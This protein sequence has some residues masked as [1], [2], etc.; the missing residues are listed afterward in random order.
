MSKPR[1]TRRRLSSD[2][3]SSSHSQRTQHDSILCSPDDADCSVVFDGHTDISHYERL[4]GMWKRL[5]ENSPAAG[6]GSRDTNRKQSSETMVGG[7]GKTRMPDQP[8]KESLMESGA[9]REP[10]QEEVDIPLTPRKTNP[11]PEIPG[12]ETP[13][14]ASSASSTT[15]IVAPKSDGQRK[16]K[17][18][19]STG[20]I[21]PRR[22]S[23]KR[24]PVTK[25]VIT[26]TE[27]RRTPAKQQ[28]SFN[29]EHHDSPRHEWADVRLSPVKIN[30]RSNGTLTN[31]EALSMLDF[32][33]DSPARPSKT[34][35]LR[36]MAAESGKQKICPFGGKLF[37]EDVRFIHTGCSQLHFPWV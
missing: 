15:N 35:S 16:A 3:E 10:C 25:L 4:N 24:T 33:D 26:P 36:K 27:P 9:D 28:P 22:S 20:E 14:A 37:R 19:E 7:D 21:T 23:R 8:T 17:T 30:S 6:T 5:S 31:E 18:V 12:P 29:R 32:L 13:N 11:L 1:Q 34:T 2:E